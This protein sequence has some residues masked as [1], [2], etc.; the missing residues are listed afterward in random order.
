MSRLFSKPTIWQFDLCLATNWPSA[1]EKSNF[2][3]PLL[4]DEVVPICCSS[5]QDPPSS[6]G[7]REKDDG[8]GITTTFDFLAL[9]PSARLVSEIFRFPPLGA[10]LSSPPWRPL[11]RLK[12]WSDFGL[13]LFLFVSGLALVE[14][15]ENCLSGVGCGWKLGSSSLDAGTRT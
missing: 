5:A 6:S 14:G 1:L 7:A 11:C 4:L 13:P 10:L 9:L 12:L 8:S 3:H 2:K 15:G